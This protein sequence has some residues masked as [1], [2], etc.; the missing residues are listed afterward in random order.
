[1]TL[2]NVKDTKIIED[3]LVEN[4]METKYEFEDE[5]PTHHSDTRKIKYLQQTLISI[6]AF[7]LL[8]VMSY[9]GS[10]CILLRL[11]WYLSM[12]PFITN[13]RLVKEKHDYFPG[14]DSSSNDVMLSRII[15]CIF[16]NI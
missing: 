4:I 15:D 14:V 16:K 11:S 2:S 3:F 13:L 5:K 1:M 12:K 9:V 10:R 8:L 6:K 7:L